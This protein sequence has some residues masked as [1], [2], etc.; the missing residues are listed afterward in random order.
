MPANGT[1]FLLGVIKTP[2]IKMLWLYN[3]VKILKT[4]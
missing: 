2:K 3:H 4:T 1:G